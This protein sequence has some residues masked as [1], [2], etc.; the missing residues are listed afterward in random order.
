MRMCNREDKMKNKLIGISIVIL[1]LALIP[2]TSMANETPEED[3]NEFG[4]YFIKTILLLPEK[5]GDYITA[6]APHSYFFSVIPGGERPPIVPPPWW[7]FKIKFKESSSYLGWLYIGKFF[8]YI[9]GYVEDL[10]IIPK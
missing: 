6:Y 10:E 3:T 9:F 7:T 5:S 1:L 4:R 2:S 8:G